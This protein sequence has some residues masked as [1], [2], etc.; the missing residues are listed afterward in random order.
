VR[1]PQRRQ[2]DPAQSDVAAH[3]A[4]PHRCRAPRVMRSARSSRRDGSRRSAKVFFPPQAGNDAINVCEFPTPGVQATRHSSVPRL[5][6]ANAKRSVTS[7]ATTLSGRTAPARS[8]R[9]HDRDPRVNVAHLPLPPSGS[10]VKRIG[11]LVAP[12]SVKQRTLKVLRQFP[13]FS[14]PMACLLPG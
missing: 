12:I 1:T 9:A 4:V 5:S 3:D 8:I 10:G 13:C 7:S 11:T 14:W 6:C 2:S